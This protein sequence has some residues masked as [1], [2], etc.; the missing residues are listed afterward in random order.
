MKLHRKRKSHR[1]QTGGWTTRGPHQSSGSGN[2][3]TAKRWRSCTGGKVEG[4]SSG[5][6][7]RARAGAKW[8]GP[9]GARMR[10]QGRESV[11]GGQKRGNHEV[12]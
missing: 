6:E 7:Q 3:L 2:D 9:Q 12:I 4:V 1:S 11:H 8:W 5:G 10:L